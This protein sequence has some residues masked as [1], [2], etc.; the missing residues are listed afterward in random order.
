MDIGTFADWVA[1]GASIGI[2]GFFAVAV[3]AAFCAAVVGLIGIFSSVAKEVE[4]G[5][6]KRGKKP[7]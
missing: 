7:Y 1:I 6:D 5:K 3:F 2:K 4:D